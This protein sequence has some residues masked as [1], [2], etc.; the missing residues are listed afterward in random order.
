MNAISRF[1]TWKKWPHIG[2]AY[3]VRNRG[4]ISW[5]SKDG[6]IWTDSYGKLVKTKGELIALISKPK[7][8]GE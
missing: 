1:S 3:R 7:Q 2:Y 6:K 5:Y 4:S 8:E